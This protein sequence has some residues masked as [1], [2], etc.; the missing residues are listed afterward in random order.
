MVLASQTIYRTLLP[1]DQLHALQGGRNHF[2]GP[3]LKCT[4]C[5]PVENA[6]DNWIEGTFFKRVEWPEEICGTRAYI[7]ATSDQIQ[8]FIHSPVAWNE[9]DGNAGNS[10]SLNELLDNRKLRAEFIAISGRIV[11]TYG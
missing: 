4:P 7:L 5:A 11:E 6:S 3:H 2:L 8:N 1:S 9:L 10:G